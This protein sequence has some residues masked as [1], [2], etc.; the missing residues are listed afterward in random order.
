MREP[1]LDRLEKRPL[2]SDGA[3]GTMLYSK[4]IPFSRCFDELNLSMPQFVKEVHLG[5]VKAGAEVVETNTFG[6][7]S[8]RLKKFELGEQVR[9]INLAGA[10]L[11]REVAR[12][13]LY[14]AVSVAPL[15]I[16][17]HPLGPQSLPEAHHSRRQQTAARL[18]RAS[19]RN[20]SQALY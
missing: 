7:T 5:Y 16:P 13:A 4:G 15:P 12:A 10:R 19:A 3:M 9:E 1:F 14:V 8:S 2:I 18:A 11:A 17:P 20:V 6:A